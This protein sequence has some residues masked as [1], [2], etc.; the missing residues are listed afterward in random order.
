M[1]LIIPTWAA[2]N[3]R[4]A[5]L[6]LLVLAALGFLSPVGA[7]AHAVLRSSS[8]ASNE[9]L[10]QPPSRV[11]LRFNEVVRLVT[12]SATDSTGARTVVQ[13]NTLGSAVILNLPSSIARGTTIVSYRVASEDGH[14]VGG[15]VVFHAGTQTATIS[16]AQQGFV[17]PLMITIWLVH[18]GSVVLL[19]VVVGGAF[20]AHLFDAGALLTSRQSLTAYLA[21]LLL[22]AN[23]YLQGLDEIGGELRFAGMR[24]FL[25]AAQSGAAIAASLAMF[26]LVLVSIPIDGRRASLAAV[27]LAM[28][29]ASV[30]FTFT[31]HCNVAEPRWL[32]RTCMFL[33]GGV[34]IFWIGS[35]IPLWR[36]GETQARSGPLLGFSR[37]IPLPFAGMLLAGGA[38]AWIEL[39]ALD[40]VLLSIYGR[41]LLLKVLLVSLLCLLAVYNRFWLTH[42]ALA[43]SPVARWRLRR[44]I[45]AEIVLA[46]AIVASAS[47]WRFAGPDQLEFA[48][49]APMLS[50]HLHSETAMAQLE[51]QLQPDGTSTARLSVMT[52]DF[53]PLEPRTVVLRVRKPNAGV[54]PIKYDLLKSPD[55][56][57]E[58]GGL[59]ISNPDGWEADV[60]ILIDDFTTAHIQG[61]LAPSSDAAATSVTRR[62]GVGS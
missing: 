9:T 27:V 29:A 59:P 24:P 10:D 25:A 20:F 45:S 38:L 62:F 16:D 21:I 1:W 52:L 43:G 13:G 35:L 61:D 14:P 36:I 33:H 3:R 15:S 39:P 4:A 37:A 22:T 46:V 56:A 5:L 30:S 32:A 28:I 19:A 17:S 26:S 2:A 18:A 40:T 7:Q 41:V 34:M 58:T 54:E 42:P 44:S 49:A 55:G 8:P 53:E 6:L 50:V 57:W 11:E 31:G 48:T 12:A 47:L 23:V 51:L 60:Q